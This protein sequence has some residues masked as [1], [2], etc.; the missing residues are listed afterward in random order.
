MNNQWVAAGGGPS[1]ALYH[2]RNREAF[3]IFDFPKEIHV[4]TFIDDNIVVGGESNAIHQY[5]FN[6]DL[7]SE[8]PTSGPCILSIVLQKTADLNILSAC[9]ASNKIDVSTNFKYKDTTL[10]FYSK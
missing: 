4:S 2:L 1:L 6:G 3:Q 8:L 7:I 9:G 5:S 10:N